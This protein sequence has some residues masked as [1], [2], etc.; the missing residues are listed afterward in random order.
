MMLQV[1]RASSGLRSPERQAALLSSLFVWAFA[2]QE[3]VQHVEQKEAG[4]EVLLLCQLCLPACLS[5]GLQTYTGLRLRYGLSRLMR[6][7]ICLG[8]GPG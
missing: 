4:D 5:S 6:V 1:F 3:N 8:P 7:L 2:R